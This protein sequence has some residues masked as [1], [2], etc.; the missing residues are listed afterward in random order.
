MLITSPISGLHQTLEEKGYG[1]RSKKTENGVS[2]TEE[3]GVYKKG[4]FG[5]FPFQNPESPRSVPPNGQFVPNLS[6]ST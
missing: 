6:F 5:D 2:C 4:C 3:I 1:V